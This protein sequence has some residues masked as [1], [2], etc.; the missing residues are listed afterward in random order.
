MQVRSY[1]P[2]AEHTRLVQLLKLSSSRRPY[3][4]HLAKVAST[5]LEMQCRFLIDSSRGTSLS[6]QRFPKISSDRP[7]GSNSCFRSHNSET[8][9][10]DRI[11]V[12]HLILCIWFPSTVERLH[13]QKR[14]LPLSHTDID[15]K[16]VDSEATL[17]N[18]T[19]IESPSTN[20]AATTHEQRLWCTQFAD[21]AR[22]ASKCSTRGGD[23]NILVRQLF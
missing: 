8:P 19:S 5:N 22:R 2:A 1:I 17:S 16:G 18:S 23:R 13:H 4:H 11:I 14:L 6:S 12:K 9:A 20:R 21:E 10:S 7:I 3:V 15:A